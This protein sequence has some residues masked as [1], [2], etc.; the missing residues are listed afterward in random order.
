MRRA[1]PEGAKFRRGQELSLLWEVNYPIL[2]LRGNP[3][4]FAEQL[5]YN[6]R[7]VL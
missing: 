6:C 1:R 7:R 5:F 4:V 2:L 3:R